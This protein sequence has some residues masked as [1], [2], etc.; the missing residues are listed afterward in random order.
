MS[1]KLQGTCDKQKNIQKWKNKYNNSLSLSQIWVYLKQKQT[2]K[3]T[4][5]QTKTTKIKL[6]SLSL[7][8]IWKEWAWSVSLHQDNLSS[9]LLI[10]LFCQVCTCVSIS[11]WC[12][13]AWQ[14]WSEVD[15]VNVQVSCLSFVSKISWTWPRSHSF[16]SMHL[17][18]LLIRTRLSYPSKSVMESQKSQQHPLNK[19]ICPCMEITLNKPLTSKWCLYRGCCHLAQSYLCSKAMTHT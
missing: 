2:N 9:D 4:E 17:I 12:K 18:I 15:T 19:E 11:V 16:E 10:V 5:A 8:D 14:P 3:R 13:R 1:Y 6:I 7:S